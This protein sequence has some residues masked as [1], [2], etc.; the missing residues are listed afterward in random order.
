MIEELSE[1]EARWIEWLHAQNGVATV[2]CNCGHPGMGVAWH[3][4]ECPGAHRA[5]MAKAREAFTEE[6]DDD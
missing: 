2:G 5:L 3:V 4:T 6:D 1:G